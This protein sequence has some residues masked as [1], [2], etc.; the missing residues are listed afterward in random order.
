MWTAFN[1]LSVVPSGGVC[2]H[3]NEPWG[4]A[5]GRIGVPQ[6]STLGSSAQACNIFIDDVCEDAIGNCICLLLAQDL[7]ICRHINDAED[8]RLLH[9]YTDC[10]QNWRSVCCI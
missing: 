4:S 8:C 9:S 7:K 2:E 1:S 5:Q 10:V 6:G 3:E